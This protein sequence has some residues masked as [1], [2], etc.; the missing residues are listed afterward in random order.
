MKAPGIG[1]DAVSMLSLL[2]A[3]AAGTDGGGRLGVVAFGVAAPA[4]TTSGSSPK[5]DEAHVGEVS[6]EFR[7]KRL[8]FVFALGDRAAASSG[9]IKRNPR[10][11]VGHLGVNLDCLC[12]CEPVVGVHRRWA[13][14][15]L[16]GSPRRKPKTFR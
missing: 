11:A 4:E 13:S 10:V 8:H 1:S 14:G 3:D 16:A 2:S 9:R 6:E 7:N 5:L 12:L 15:G